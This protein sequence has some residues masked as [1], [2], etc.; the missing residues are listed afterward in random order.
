MWL[1]EEARIVI[2]ASFINCHTEAQK[3]GARE[4]RVSV[5]VG[6][7]FLQLNSSCGVTC[8]LDCSTEVMAA[9]WG[10]QCL[11]GQLDAVLGAIQRLNLIAWEVTYFPS[12]SITPTR[13]VILKRMRTA[14][15][16]MNPPRQH[17]SEPQQKNPSNG[18]LPDRTKYDM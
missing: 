16:S 18:E 1:S 9:W 4:F 2:A 10:L 13:A 12:T 7:S 17:S 6:G 5:K 8:T 14:G 15:R 3:P 11:M